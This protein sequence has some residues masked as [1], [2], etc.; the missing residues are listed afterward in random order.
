MSNTRAPAPLGGGGGEGGTVSC[1]NG[2]Q[3]SNKKNAEVLES[4]HT[5]IIHPLLP[6][7]YNYIIIKLFDIVL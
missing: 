1:Y 4:K 3:N 2:Y 6:L 5:P 7:F